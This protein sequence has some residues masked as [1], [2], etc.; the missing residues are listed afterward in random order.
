MVPK[1]GEV[2]KKS[3]SINS[4]EEL[5]LKGIIWEPETA[6][7]LK[8][9]VVIAHGMAEIIERYDDFATTLTQNGYIVYG[10]NQ[11]GH[12][13]DAPLL[14]YLGE[15]GWY[16]LREDYKHVVEFVRSN[17]ADLPVFAM[18]HSMGS[19]VVRDF[20]MDY[21]YLVHGVI[22]SGTG[23]YPK[24][25]L[26]F[27]SWLSNRD[28]AKHGD[29]HLSK[30]I[31][32]LA[33]RGNNK[34]IKMPSTAFD[35]LSRDAEQVKA[36]VNNPLCGQM[37]PSSFYKAFFSGLLKLMY[38]PECNNFKPGLPMLLISGAEDPIGNYGK[39]V[40]KTEQ[41]YRTLGYK[42][43]QIL[44]DGGRHEMLNEINKHQ[45]YDTLI[46]WLENQL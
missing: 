41:F 17:H 37:H 16:K 32:Q 39:G 8:G 20:L 6:E 15:D 11:R 34:R 26:S 21:S 1:K 23:F 36:Y 27:G 31:D 28:V 4:F 45:V 12:G 40:D 3:F 29:R 35:W 10:Y 43:E 46:S 30:T 22:L 7:A 42:T 14:G 24:I 33:F 44:F 5:V 9:I 2:M 18:G 38:Q 25:T 13:P 19:F